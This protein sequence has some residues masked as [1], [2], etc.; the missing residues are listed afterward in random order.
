TGTSLAET[1]KMVRRIE[2]VLQK[3]PEIAGFTRRTG[4][5]MGMFATEQNSGDILVRLKPHSQRER[6]AEEIMSEQ[7][8]TLARE[9]P[10]VDI[11]FIQ[12]LQDMLGDLQGTPEPVE[13]KIFGDNI[14]VLGA[15]T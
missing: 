10:A 1:D 7:R 15:I 12:L 5:E 3:T 9:L 2:A 13:V 6:D 14:N 8:D 11:D 4:T